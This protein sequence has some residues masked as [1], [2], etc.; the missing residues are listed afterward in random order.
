M[1]CSKRRC[2]LIIAILILLTASGNH[3]LGKERDPPP[4]VLLTYSAQASPSAT[5]LQLCSLR[6]RKYSLSFDPREDIKRHIGELDLVLQPLG[7]RGRD[8]NLLVVN[9]KWHGYQPYTFGAADYVRGANNSAAG[10]E[11]VI[12]VPHLHAQL[13]VDVVEVQV[14][15][16]KPDDLGKVRYWFSK[17][18]LRISMRDR[19][20]GG[21]HPVSP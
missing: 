7:D 10:V 3:A 17:L 15:A 16:E 2:A 19:P 5:P 18:V 14:D 13:V 9:D 21:V 6:G 8:L 11:R 20:G 4:Q 12:D 1:R